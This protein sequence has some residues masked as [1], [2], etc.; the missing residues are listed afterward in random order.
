M[1]KMFILFAVVFSL[2]SCTSA[3][4]SNSEMVSL[5]ESFVEQQELERDRT[6]SAFRLN[7][8]AQLSDEY[9]VFRSSPSRHYLIKLVPRCNEIAFS[10]GLLLHRRFGNTLS[11]G[12]DFVYV[13]D[14]LPFKC[15]INRIYPL[16]REQHEL[17]Q[18]TIQTEIKEQEL[19]EQQLEEAEAEG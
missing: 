2:T 12:S 15:Y 14:S 18:A 13:P 9:L 3:R 11:E 10:A 6:V 5:I 17:L 8:Y 1:K 16:N 19:K 7:S 4:L